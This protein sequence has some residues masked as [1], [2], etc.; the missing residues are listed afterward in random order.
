MITGRPGRFYG[1][2]FVLQV[3]SM[4]QLRQ[5]GKNLSVSL[6]TIAGVE[7]PAYWLD[8]KFIR[9]KKNFCEPLLLQVSVLKK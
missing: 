3:K 4:V 9:S 5:S 1:G 7:L 6:E 8:M 2:L